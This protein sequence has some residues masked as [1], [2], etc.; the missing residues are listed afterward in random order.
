MPGYC[1]PAVPVRG[2]PGVVLL[3]GAVEQVPEG[4]LVGA[5]HP[6]VERARVE[7]AAQPGRTGPGWPT[8][9]A[10]RVQRVAARVEPL[11]AVRLVPPQPVE[12][13]LDPGHLVALPGFHL[14]PGPVD[15]VDLRLGAH[16]GE[17]VV[18]RAP[19]LLGEPVAVD[20][21]HQLGVPAPGPVMIE[22]PA[23]DGTAAPAQQV[24][25]PG[26]DRARGDVA[27]VDDRPDRLAPVTGGLD[28]RHFGR[29]APF[30]DGDDLLHGA[31]GGGD[32]LPQRRLDL[33]G[34]G[35]QVGR[36]LL[37]VGQLGHDGSLLLVRTI[38]FND[39]KPHC[40]SSQDSCLESERGT[41][42]AIPGVAARAHRR[43]RAACAD[44]AAP[45]DP[46]RAGR[47]HRRLQAH[48][49]RERAPPGRGR[50]GRRHRPA[51]RGWPWPWP[52]RRLLRPGRPCW[53]GPGRQHRPRR[54]RR[55]VHRPPRRAGLPG[56]TSHH[57]PGPPGPVG[58][59]PARGRRPVRSRGGPGPPG[60]RSVRS[61][62][63]PG[64]PG[65]PARSVG[66]A[67]SVSPT[68]HASHTRSVSP[69]GPAGRG[70][71]GRPGGPGHRPDGSTCRTARF[72]SA[73]WT[74]SRC[75]PR[76]WPAPSSSTTT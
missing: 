46:G 56:R 48:G 33:L 59:G 54:H 16:A 55:R 30:E 72:C 12:E 58:R 44:A 75:S 13:P 14:R 27:V 36:R 68:Q 43:A 11:H 18:G 74:R 21:V 45:P 50:P 15:G 34:R 66:P 60:H 3:H 63:G 8:P 20:V 73:T 17:E 24:P 10:V 26:G 39:V 67:R 70:Q 9:D 49:G 31:A 5:G 76:W 28:L 1:G 51:H 32:P 47:G 37:P 25:V 38:Y 23:D 40:V 53:P 7:V 65:S 2:V 64:P 69:T 6:Q 57:P 41:G 52:R 29:Q 22:L 35:G 71:R 62:G 42:Q 19:V 4:L 61:R